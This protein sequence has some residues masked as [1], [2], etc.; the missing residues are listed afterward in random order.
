[1]AIKVLQGKR[2][3]PEMPK[4]SQSFEE[5][6]KQFIHQTRPESILDT[7][8]RVGTATG[9]G[10]LR[11]LEGLANLATL[12]IQAIAGFPKLSPLSEQIEQE[13]GITPGQQDPQNLVERFVQRFGSQLP[14]AALGGLGGIAQSA[15]GSGAGALAGQAGLPE[16]AQDIA[17]FGAGI[18]SGL[19]K[20]KIPTISK[21]Q[22][23]QY[24]LA[25]AAVKPETKAVA[26]P[27]INAMKNVEQQLGTEVNETVGNK[28]RH[29]LKIIDQNLSKDK[30]NPTTAMD[31][32]RNLYKLGNSFSDADAK[33]YI[34]PLTKGVNEFFTN[35]A[36]ENPIFF[37]H[38]SKADQFTQL[39]NMTS[40]FD[41]AGNLFGKIPGVSG[42]VINNLIKY[43]L[44]KTLGKTEKVIRSIATKPVAREHYF[45]AGKAILGQDPGL[46]LKAMADLR[47]SLPSEIIED[48]PEEKPTATTQASNKGIKILQGKKLV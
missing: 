6:P 20:G 30:I 25:R 21:S 18:S 12:P 42:P 5:E 31:L 33:S 4:T 41:K 11:N 15:I 10:A 44:G 7:L 22:K 27:V 32:R 46:F 29:A 26:E 36:I 45:K 23:Q 13:Y 3:A 1:M 8:G 17:Q 35:Y 34:E 24:E 14:L 37:K 16:I 43:T 48:L 39:K 19:L 47:K 38:L 9:L 2:I 40:I 28:V